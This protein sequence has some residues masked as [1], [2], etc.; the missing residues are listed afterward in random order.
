MVVAVVVDDDDVVVGDIIVVV[1]VGGV[2]VN[3][4]FLLVFI[5]YGFL[6]V[7]KFLPN[8]VRVDVFKPVLSVF[9]E[10]KEK[11]EIIKISI[12]S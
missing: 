11:W 6:K 5:L 9:R 12:K 1:V 3:K 4:L 8:V 7:F 10:E 2:V